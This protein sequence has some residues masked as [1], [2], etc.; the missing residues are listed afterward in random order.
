VDSLLEVGLGRVVV[1]MLDVNPKVA[2]RGVG[3]LE[4][5]G[6]PV[7]VGLF[8]Q[9]CRRLNEAYIT[10]MMEKRPFVVLKVAS[11]L[12]GKI[13]TYRGQS[14]WISGEES[15]KRVH[16]LRACVDA[17]MVGAATAVADDPELT[18][19][20]VEGDVR[21]P[22]RVVVDSTLRLP[23]TARLL[24]EGSE[25]KTVVATTAKAPQERRRAVEAMG[26]DV[27][28]LPE[29]QGRV[30]LSSLMARLAEMDVVS[31][32]LEGGGELN[33][34]MVEEGLVDKVLVIIA[35]MLLGGGE[36]PTV[37]DGLGVG[38][39]E[40]AWRLNELSFQKV[41]EDLHVEGYLERGA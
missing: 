37:L 13:A 16:A 32:L 24:A 34:S 19:R 15:R 40:E 27:L 17:V 2:G 28:V 4:E 23:A 38:S 33:A 22:V 10:W 11:S 14:R 36:A 6:L 26:R 5:A 39:I 25:L 7:E 18:V 20:M 8:E 9:E 30:D 41:G 21:Q 3:R 35:P 12:D 1:G 29:R 31:L